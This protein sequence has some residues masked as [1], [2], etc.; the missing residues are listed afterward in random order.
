MTMDVMITV[1]LDVKPCVP[2]ESYRL[3]EVSAAPFT[4]YATSA[5][6]ILAAYSSRPLL[7]F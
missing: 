6:K 7:I 1:F 5:A 2:V 3:L 4:E